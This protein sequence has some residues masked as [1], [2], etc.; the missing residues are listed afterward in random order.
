M[1]RIFGKWNDFLENEIR[2]I[3]EEKAVEKM[4][5]ERGGKKILRRMDC[6]V[7]IIAAF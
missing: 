6:L 3:E 7:Q 5:E 4:E 1:N 2:G